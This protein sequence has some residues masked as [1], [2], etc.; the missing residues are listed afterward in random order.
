MSEGSNT[1]ITPGVSPELVF[2]TITAFMQSAVLRAA[3]DLGV[4]TV[5]AEG[6]KTI[7]E[8]AARCQASERGI[9]IMCDFLTVIGFLSKENGRYENSPTSAAFLDRR[10]PAYIG[11]IARFMHDPTIMGPW[12]DLTNII[13]SGKTSLPGQ[14]SV[15]PD[16]P[17][18]VE[19]AHSMAPMM[20]AVAAPLGRIVLADGAG[21]MRVLDIAAGHG[22]FGI[23][24][25]KQNPEAHIVALDWPAVLEVARG[26]A[27]KAVVEDRY[28][29]LPGDAFHT[30]FQG[31][32]DVVLV[33]NFFHHFNRETCVSLLK[34]I[35]AVLKPG[36]RTATLE[37]VPNE[38]RVSPG[39][40]A[41]FAMTMLA[42][43]AEG[44]AYTYAEYD[45]M[46]REAGFE[47]T[48]L[49]DMPPSPHRI[50][51]GYSG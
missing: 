12:Q 17:V 1:Q 21:P 18:W 23:E 45:S 22:L 30:D 4:F 48:V 8:I 46:H 42:T 19:F 26:N 11:S 37:F 5:I 50:I 36:G 41:T 7:P 35:R 25:A 24:V 15:D 31:P 51:T 44:D 27:V 6:S 33:T 14:G 28:E 16:H 39:M 38:D 10:L 2:H 49:H 13:R 29:T 32:Y 3:I 43:T 47:R 9:R 20:A 34:K 40:P